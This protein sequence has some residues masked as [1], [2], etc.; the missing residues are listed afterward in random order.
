M[1]TRAQAR[2][3]GLTPAE[4]DDLVRRR[5]WRPLLPGVYLTSA[6]APTAAARVRGALLW[7]DPAPTGPAPVLAGAA[8]AWWYGWLPAPPPIVSIMTGRRPGRRR[9]G[10]VLHQRLPAPPDLGEHRGLRVTGHALTVL[11]TAVELGPAGAELLDR[12]AQTWL[13]AT[14]LHAAYRRNPTAG[15]GRVLAAA[16][17]RSTTSAPRRLRQLLHASG[18]TGWRCA[19]P[20]AAVVFPH[21]AVAVEV[22]GW[23]DPD[24]DRLPGGGA[25]GWTVLRVRWAD[26]VARPAAVLASV[27]EAVA[28]PRSAP[29]ASAAAGAGVPARAMPVTLTTSAPAAGGADGAASGS[30]PAGGGR[31]RGRST[32]ESV[33][34]SG[35]PS[36]RDGVPGA[37]PASRGRRREPLPRPLLAR[38]RPAPGLS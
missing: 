7:A 21:A 13:P 3:A 28:G 22:L 34:S 11:Q 9:T 10:I 17:E 18:T 25:P 2:A 29:A 6:A 30:R 20:A 23:L 38:G 16:A 5:R 19:G 31:D 32:G 37:A 26:L 14:D 1:L 36:A 12:A 15:G 33:Q 27:A 4:I 35:R 8:A 24:P